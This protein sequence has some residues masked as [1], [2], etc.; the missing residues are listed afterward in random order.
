MGAAAWLAACPAASD[1]SGSSESESS[2]ESTSTSTGETDATTDASTD[3]E[4]GTETSEDPPRPER[5]LLTSD[6]RAKRISLIDYAALRDG[7]S[8]RE[9]ALWKEIDLAAHEPGPI[10]A[11]LTPDGSLA[12][13]AVGPSFFATQ[14]GTLAGAGPGTVPE[15]GL[16][17]IV[18][19][20]SGSVIAELET[21]HYP[22]GVA[23]TDDGS[24]AWTA[25]FGGNGQSGTTI[26]HI[27]L[28]SHTI[29][30]EIDVGPGPEQLDILGQLAIVVVS[31]GTVRLFDLADPSGTISPG[32]FVS[33]DPSGVLFVSGGDRVA[34][35]NSL[36]PPGYSLLELADPFAPALLDMTQVVGIPYGIAPGYDDEQIVMTS[37]IGSS[38]AIQLYDTATSELLQEIEAPHLGFPLGIAF[39]PEAGLAMVPIPSV[40]VLFLADF[41]TGETREIDWQDVPGPTYV[42]LEQP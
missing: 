9:E 25:N 33:E 28:T 12:I 17:L 1:E 34:I 30:E 7:A 19:I 27:D 23:I 31:D 40:N 14:A 6:W 42:A 21:A 20:D 36:G 16:V 10:Q 35:T 24:A 8:T 26:S 37:I 4:T 15:G 41:D 32:F 5:L 13:V 3:T 29:V 2:S 22:H 18:E 38:I 11:E 39:D